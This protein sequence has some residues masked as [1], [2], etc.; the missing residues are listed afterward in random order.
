MVKG[1]FIFLSYYNQKSVSIHYIFKK[2]YSS[3]RKKI[4]PFSRKKGQRYKY[5]SQK[6]QIAKNMKIFR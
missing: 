6:R 3:I 2:F 1:T 4:K 5:N